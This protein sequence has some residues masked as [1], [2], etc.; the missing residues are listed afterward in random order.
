MPILDPAGGNLIRFKVTEGLLEFFKANRIRTSNSPTSGRWKVGDIITAEH[1]ARFY[2]YTMFMVGQHVTQLESFSYSLSPLTPFIKIGRYCS[3]SWNVSI[4]GPHHPIHFVTSSEI[5]YRRDG[6]FAD[7]FG[8][9]GQ[10]EWKFLD[11]PQRGPVNIGHDVWVGQDVLIQGGVSIGTGA[12]IGAGAVVTK[13]VAPYE[14]VGGVPARRLRCRFDESLVNA[15]LQSKW[16]S[17]ALPQ[18]SGLA[19]GDPVRFLDELSEAV[20]AGAAV[21]FRSDLGSVREIV[22]QTDGYGRQ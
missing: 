20:E 1:Y 17:Y 3:I 5:L 15:L 13:D 9:F 7:T 6:L 2:S 21:P 10:S 14:I 18:I 8:E 4:M 11:N 12:V 19:W 22:E 16:W